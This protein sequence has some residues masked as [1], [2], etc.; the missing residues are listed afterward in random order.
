M[1]ITLNGKLFECGEDS[2]ILSVLTEKGICPDTIIA[3]LDGEIYKT[4]DF[5]N[6]HLKNDSILEILQ[7]VGGG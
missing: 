7:F 3:E 2:T 6:I 4:D 5:E 1:E